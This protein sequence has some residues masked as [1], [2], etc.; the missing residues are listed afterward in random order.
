MLF[1]ITNWLTGSVIFSID[2][3][4]E[5]WPDRWRIAVY[6][7][8]KAEISLNN[9]ELNGAELNGAELNYAKLNGAEL[10]D[11]KLN[12]AE[13]ND[14][15]LNF[16]K[17]NG[18][19]LNY[20][21]LNYAKLN[22]AKLNNAKLNGAE[23]NNAKLNGAELNGAELNDAKLNG[24]KLNGAELTH[25]RDDLWAV[26]SAAPHEVQGLRA[27]LIAG[28]VNGSVY[29]GECA[30]LIGTIANLQHRAYTDLPN[31]RPNSS[32][33]IER[34]F[35]AIEEGDTPE[36]SQVVKIIVEWIDDWRAR[37]QKA[38]G[39]KEQTA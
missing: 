24:A 30:C 31:L 26:L 32:R 37:M 29:K 4:T 9:A 8:I 6:A 14:A 38:F 15:E 33:P 7:A 20:A 13:L 3:T 21:E 5:Q 28:R 1:E 10:N 12:G 17:L 39:S 18:A 25:I 27:A 16:A 19:E 34:F 23:L 22:N 35:L 11:A 36:T 2:L